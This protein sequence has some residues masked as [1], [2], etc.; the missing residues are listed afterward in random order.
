MFGK[1]YLMTKP[2]IYEDQAVKPGIWNVIL[3][4]DRSRWGYT[5]INP[6]GGS[7]SMNSVASN[8]AG[9]YWR[10]VSRNQFNGADRVWVIEVVWDPN[11]LSWDFEKRRPSGPDED[12]G[13][14]S[15]MKSYWLSRNEKF[16]M[17]KD[18]T[19]FKFPTGLALAHRHI[20]PNG[21]E[22]GWVADTASVGKNVYVGKDA[23]VF[24]RAKVFDF[25]QI[26][27]GQV[28]GKAELRDAVQ[29]AG[30]AKVFGNAKLSNYVR[31]FD[32]AKVFGNAKLS[33]R[34]QVLDASKV[35]GDA[36]LYGDVQVQ[37]HAEIFGKASFGGNNVFQRTDRVDF[38][39][40]DVIRGTKKVDSWGN[41]K[42]AY[43]LMCGDK[44]MNSKAQIKEAKQEVLRLARGTQ[45]AAWGQS[46][47]EIE[48]IKADWVDFGVTHAGLINEL[49][50]IVKKIRPRQLAI[51]QDLLKFNEDA[52]QGEGWPYLNPESA[53]AFGNL[54]VDISYLADDLAPILKKFAGTKIAMLNNLAN[55]KAFK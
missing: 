27:G 30:D 47:E 21:T 29:V 36:Q 35:Y 10:A 45:K 8:R 9:A 7:S 53:S 1:G 50:R 14:W 18:P 24:D 2:I 31:V 13:A 6:Q 54:C 41:R 51:T 28:Y 38:G 19:M 3:R 25:V 49:R 26:Y 22:G 39:I 12:L 5:L 40:I 16:A 48:A 42:W 20:N 44:K 52:A 32:N 11:I 23:L 55:L 17:S 34:V 46:D 33:N 43:S 4:K 37:D 15:V